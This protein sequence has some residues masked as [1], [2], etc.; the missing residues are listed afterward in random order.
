MS[1][2]SL[3]IIGLI[4]AAILFVAVNVIAGRTLGTQ[5]IDLTQG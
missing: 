5:R 4:S 3:A 2:R 1:R